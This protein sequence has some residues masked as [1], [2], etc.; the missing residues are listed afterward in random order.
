MSQQKTF[1][2]VE[3]L[4]IGKPLFTQFPGMFT[5][6]KGS[7]H[8]SLHRLG[9]NTVFTFSEC[10]HVTFIEPAVIFYM[11]CAMN[12]AAYA[13]ILA[14]IFFKAGEKRQVFYWRSREEVFVYILVALTGDRSFHPT[15]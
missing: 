7:F 5:T 3:I 14:A 13:H 1:P 12:S 9:M 8:F 2:A 6:P 4:P 10:F 15:E 11:D